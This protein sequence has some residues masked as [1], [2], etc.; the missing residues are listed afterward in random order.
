MA[1]TPAAVDKFLGQLI[2]A[3]PLAPRVEAADIQA[4][5]D[6][7]KGGFTLQPWDWEYYAEKVRKAKYDLDEAQI[8]SVFRTG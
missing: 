6:Q 3:R 2:P 5:I 8:K 7:E 1:K 4:V